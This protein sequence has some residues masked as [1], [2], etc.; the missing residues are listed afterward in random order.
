LD[1]QQLDL[2]SALDPVTDCNE[3]RAELLKL[4]AKTELDARALDPA[5]D[6]NVVHADWSTLKT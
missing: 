2:D 4:K 6:C 5:K 1:S 3:G